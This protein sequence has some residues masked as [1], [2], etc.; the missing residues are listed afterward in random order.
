MSNNLLHL[1]QEGASEQE[2]E[3]EARNFS[4]GIRQSAREMVLRGETTL[5]EMV[6]VTR[7]E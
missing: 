1:I 4:P 5:E 3:K 6:R 7:E 2:L